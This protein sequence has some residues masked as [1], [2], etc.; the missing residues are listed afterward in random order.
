[1]CLCLC[2]CFLFLHKARRSSN[3]HTSK[4]RAKNF[5]VPQKGGGVPHNTAKT[6]EAPHNPHSVIGRQR[7]HMI[8]FSSKAPQQPPHN[9]PTNRS[10]NTSQTIIKYQEYTINSPGRVDNLQFLAPVGHNQNIETVSQQSKS[11]RIHK[12]EHHSQG[13]YHAS[14]T[15]NHPL[16]Q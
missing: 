1:M 9:L 11:D 8:P 14:S 12:H 15:D 5:R 10:N 16:Y 4:A 3:S 2:L 7:H 13:P 6:R